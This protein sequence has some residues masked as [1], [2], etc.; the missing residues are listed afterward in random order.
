M[1]DVH[2]YISMYCLCVF[3]MLASL[4]LKIVHP[5][6]P[7]PLPPW[8]LHA[9]VIRTDLHSEAS[10]MSPAKP[11]DKLNCFH[12]KIS[13]HLW[14]L[15]RSVYDT[16][17]SSCL[18]STIFMYCRHILFYFRLRRTYLD[19]TG[20]KSRVSGRT[21]LLSTQGCWAETIPKNFR[22]HFHNGTLKGPSHQIRS[23][24]KWYGQ[25][26]LGRDMRRWT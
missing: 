23:A 26:G 20:R 10:P 19:A 25:I 12:F 22:K 17:Y 13:I 15:L 3:I 21:G 16:S 7:P 24:W 1:D 9:K 4:T 6:P 5:P 8:L 14:V 18:F 11:R 2:V